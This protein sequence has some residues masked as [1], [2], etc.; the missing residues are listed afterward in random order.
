MREC[1]WRKDES[2]YRLYFRFTDYRLCKEFNERM[3]LKIRIGTGYYVCILYFF[4]FG[5]KNRNT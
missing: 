2:T 1:L 3:V 4:I 5:I